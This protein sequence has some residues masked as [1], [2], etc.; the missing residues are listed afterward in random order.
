MTN[1]DEITIRFY[2]LV[3]LL[4][5]HQAFNSINNII[6]SE[7]K[8]TGVQIKQVWPDINRRYKFTEINWEPNQ[9][10]KLLHPNKIIPSIYFITNVKGIQCDQALFVK[11]QGQHKC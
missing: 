6:K 9:T 7:I 2:K 1:N 10:K 11:A 5:W 8:Y 3:H 4:I